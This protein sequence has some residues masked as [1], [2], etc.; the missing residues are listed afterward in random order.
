MPISKTNPGTGSNA[1]ASRTRPKTALAAL[2]GLLLLASALPGHGQKLLD[3]LR[4]LGRDAG[5][6]YMEPAA[7]SFG[8]AMN[9]GWFHRAPD[10]Q[11]M[12]LDVDFGL[13][14]VGGL[15]VETPKHF[16]GSGTYSFNK[17]QTAG[18]LDSLFNA[19]Q[20]N[21]RIAALSQAQRNALRDTLANR[22]SGP[23][24]Q[25]T[26]SGPTAVGPKNDSLYLNLKEISVP[27]TVPASE[28][29]D[30]AFDTTIAIGTDRRISIPASGAFA[31]L[32]FLPVMAPSLTVGT[33]YGTQATL[34]WLPAVKI[35]SDI[36]KVSLFG[37]G[38]QHNVSYWMGPEVPVDLTLD[39][40]G[41]W[42]EVQHTFTSNAL[43]GGATVSK[44]FGS[45]TLGVTP[46]AGAAVE[47]SDFDAAFDATVETALGPI[48][49]EVKFSIDGKNNAHYTLGC[50]LQFFHVN[51]TT[52]YNFAEYD[53]FSAGLM[54]ML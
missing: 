19:L 33:L 22:I 14:S 36:G 39:V 54:V 46:F 5:E 26:F 10:R 47:R 6:A 13:V 11:M 9:T 2:F 17:V 48:E 8:A 53:T 32:P 51:L 1:A 41:Q 42:L 4:I 28:A 3:N 21:P 27:I 31:D 23:D 7:S 29:G 35:S 15:F 49:R 37:F 12:G 34:R 20:G 45:R 25:V 40:H 43:A 38:V 24:L 52:D 18:V 16:S 50:A 44:T 30:P